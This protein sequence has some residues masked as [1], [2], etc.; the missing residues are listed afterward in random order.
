M[1][2]KNFRLIAGFAAVS[3]VFASVVFHDAAAHSGNDRVRPVPP[4]PSVHG[5]V[6]T[7]VTKSNYTLAERFTPEKVSRMVHSFSVVPRWIDGTDSFWY[8]YETSEGTFWWIVD[9][10]KGTKKELFD[11][12]WLAAELTKVLKDP[13]DGQHL[14]SL[15]LRFTDDGQRCRFT[16]RSKWE[17]E[18]QLDRKTG[19]EKT[20][21]KAYVFEYDLA[22]GRL[23]ILEDYKQELP[24]GWANVSPDGN[25]VVYVKDYNL[26]YMDGEN[27]AKAMAN[28]KDSTIVE[29]Q[30]TFD[31]ELYNG[32]GYY[33]TSSSDDA[34][35]QKNE[36]KRIEEVVWSPDSKHFLVKRWDQRSVKDLWVIDYTAKPRPALHTYKYQMPGEDGGISHIEI[37]DTET[38]TKREVIPGGF[39]DEVANI[40]E[41]SEEFR[42][43][44][45]D[46]STLIKRWLGGPDEFYITRLSRDFKNLDTYRVDVETLTAV[47][48]IKEYFNK[49]LD[50]RPMY[51]TDGPGSD[52]IYWSEIDGWAH[53]YRY[54]QDGELKNRITSGPWHV[55]DIVKVDSENETVYFL[56]NGRE[57][58]INPYY[59]FLYSV[60]F[61]GS[62]LRL[63]SPGDAFHKIAMSDDG[64]YFV[65]NSSRVD[66]TP[67]SVLY[68]SD[69]KKIIDLEEADL[70]Q[71]FAS[72]YE[73]P[74]TFTVKAADGIT[75]L[76][77]VMYTPY[78][79]D[80]TKLYPI[81]EYVY[82]GPQQEGVQY[83]YMEPRGTLD[84][85]AQLGFIVVTVGNRGG[86][87]SRSKWYHTYGYGNLRDY[88]LEDKK[89]AAV[90]L[91][92]RYPFMDIT[93]VGITGH[94]GGGF[95]ST[96]A[97][98][99]YPEF[100]KVAV[101][102]AGNHDNAIY[103]RMWGEKYHGVKE[104][105]SKGDTT[106]RFSVP[107]NEDIAKNLQGR[108]LLVTGDVD[109]NVHPG[110]TMR[111]VEQLIRAGK[112]FDM[113][114]LPGQSHGFG[115]MNNYFFWRMA[116]YFCRYLIGDY[117][118]SVDIPQ[119]KE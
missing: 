117:Q 4:P 57:K 116:D 56:A 47:P 41:D 80:T 66:M 113:L 29:R 119:L 68:N 90:Q 75:D 28:E 36:K 100:F 81:I 109:N 72:G 13:Y 54:G 78:D 51:L 106:Y 38:F 73:F 37:F 49:Y 7:P 89:T 87:P 30:I 86:H 3:M 82:P 103:N 102:C 101:S 52:I 84:R 9:C 31:G 70:S 63:L 8:S 85:L 88:G 21:K 93:R 104:Q 6:R 27:Y 76:Y 105:I 61:D 59:E 69:G 83:S 20:V 18:T 24:Q 62:D 58:G 92:D 64:K 53:L 19:K 5:G 60:R 108:L 44:R 118:N 17:E 97:I 43:K 33:N 79:L 32:Y 94:S 35:K 15:S 45:E 91:A 42:L 50:S 22:S 67:V 71:L 16:V 48:V 55:D 112:R 11:R 98:L 107:N 14:P 110:N 74:T 95:M 96:A 39:K 114:V 65:D 12:D 1:N 99:K 23:D 40:V 34:G 46:Y 111:V 26:W 115:D 77:G 10:R 2:M 25:H